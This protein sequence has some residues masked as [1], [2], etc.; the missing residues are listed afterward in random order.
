MR[1]CGE[2]CLRSSLTLVALLLP[3][4]SACDA[5]S[6]SSDDESLDPE[7]SFMFVQEA[8]SGTFADNGD[9]THTLTLGGVS[10][11]TVY[12]SDRP[13][14]VTGSAPMGD[15]VAGFDWD[16]ENPPNAAVVLGEAADSSE[17]DTIIVQ[18][19]DPRYEPAAQT[20]T[21]TVRI[22][23]NYDGS[24]LAEYLAQADASLPASFGAVSL[25]IDDCPDKSYTCTQGTVCCDYPSL[26]TTCGSLTLGTCWHWTSASCRVCHDANKE[27]NDKYSS[28]CDGRCESECADDCDPDIP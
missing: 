19:Y 26:G 18:I 25:F 4:L 17:Q 12:F 7:T 22:L 13:E 1:C 10:P 16:E 28:C 5:S 24:G 14:T 6:G 21:Y 15:F 20:L 3:A 23:D 8:A 2:T 9:G 27:C 11:G